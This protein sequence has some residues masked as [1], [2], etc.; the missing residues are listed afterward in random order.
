M[1]VRI[2]PTLPKDD[3]RNG[4]VRVERQLIDDPD[5]TH[6]I[7]A[8]VNQRR[9]TSDADTGETIPTARVLH[10]EAITGA[11][12]DSARQLLTSAC[13]ARTGSETLPFESDEQL[14]LDGDD[15]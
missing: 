8:V 3:A 13:K 6:V 10:I 5:Q 1:S 9:V 2:W 12:A 15:D 7:V 11:D 14:P 4:L